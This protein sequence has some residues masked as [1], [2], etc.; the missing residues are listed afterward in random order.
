MLMLKE[1]EPSS[2]RETGTFPNFGVLNFSKVLVFVQLY[3]LYDYVLLQKRMSAFQVC[4]GEV[5]TSGKI[6]SS[7]KIA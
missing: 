3:G 7:N 6:F 4:F 2:H 1:T 5:H